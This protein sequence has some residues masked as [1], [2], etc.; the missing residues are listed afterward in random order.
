MR[1]QVSFTLASSP[2]VGP[3][4]QFVVA[5]DLIGNGKLDLAT[6]NQDN[7][8][9]SL[10]TN[11]GSGAFSLASSP[12][13][14]VDPVALF[15]GDVNGDGSVDLISVNYIGG[16]FTVLTNNGSGGFFPASTPMVGVEPL[17]LTGA[18][19]NGDGKMDLI[20][21]NSSPPSVSVLTN[22]GFGSFALSGTY[23]VGINPW[24]VIA[25]DVNRDGKMDLITANYAARTL[26]ILTND[27]SGGFVTAGTYSVGANPR[28]VAAADLNRDGTVD[29]ISANQGDNTLTV[30]TNDGSGGFLTAAVYSVGNQPVYV[31]AADVNGDGAVDLISVNYGDG[32][33]SVMTNDGSGR[34]KAAGTFAVG[35]GPRA[36]A[37]ADVNGDGA[38]DLITANQGS[39]TLSILTNGTPYPPASAPII[40][41]QPRSQTNY[42]GTTATFNVGAK[43]ITGLQKFSYQWRL[44]GTNLPAGTNNVLMLSIVSL[45]QAGS[46]DVVITNSAG[47]ITSSPAILDVSAILV[48]VNGQPAAKTNSAVISAT[49]TLSGFPGGFIYFTLDGSLPTTSSAIYSGP[50]ILSNSAVVQAM[51]LSA[52]FS[53]TAYSTPVTVQIL[54]PLNVSTPGGG[55]FTVNGLTTS[56]DSNYL[57]GGAVTLEAVANSGWSFIGWQG[58][59]G[60][61]NNPLFLTVNETNS[62]Q[63]IF[64]TVVTTDTLGGGNIVLNQANPIPYGTILT[65]SAVASPGSYFLEWGGAINGTNAPATLDVTNPVPNISALFTALPDSEYSLSVVVVGNGSVSNTLQRSYYSPGESVT[66]EA[67]TN[68]GAYFLGWAQ[69]ATGTNNLLTVLM[70]TN[71]TIRANFGVLP[72]VSI[73]PSNQTVLAGSNALLTATAYGPSPLNYQWQNALGAIPGAT[74]AMLTIYD[75]QPGSAGNYWVVVSNSF[76]SVTSAVATVAVIGLPSITNQ[77]VPATVTIGHTAS[78]VVGASGW[79]NLSY[80]W[81]LNGTNL[82]GATNAVLTLA[83]AFPANHGIYAVAITNVYGSVTSNPVGLTVLPLIIALPALPPNGP[84]QFTFDTAIGIHYEVEYSTNLTQWSPLITVSGNNQP[85]MLSDPNAESGPQRYYRIILSDQ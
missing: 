85:L 52:D 48:E 4:P 2:A 74:N 26:S 8:T 59:A 56:P 42:V 23:S 57:T 6:P 14:D 24:C 80:Q 75:A 77:S 40:T 66:L 32:T 21:A 71:K 73:T 47:S 11:N 17:S 13:T 58:G 72:M 16:S 44:N 49:L 82:P 12:A 53:Q 15:A 35:S 1:A 70:T 20:S 10:L 5:A 60:G 62:I 45:S 38:V 18:D 3:E 34:F 50:I 27:G 22:N 83:N 78:F 55:T 31:A 63:A 65:A 51:T 37:V 7:N 39:S 61:T 29:L 79:P 36:V 81:L 33:L 41:S 25:A 43:A 68:A 9:L 64:G 69:D 84:F 46:Y 28:S 76:G 19:V 54:A 30:L 67:I